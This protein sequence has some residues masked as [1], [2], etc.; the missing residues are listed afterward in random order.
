MLGI[1]LPIFAFSHCRDVVVEVSKSG[2]LGVLGAAYFT[3]EAFR[4]ELN[5]IVDHVG[6]KPFGVDIL[7]PT[8]Y[9]TMSETR[10]SP[11]DLPSVQTEYL[12]AYLDRNGIAPLPADAADDMIADEIRKIALT[13]QQALELVE[14]ALEYPISLVVNALGVPPRELV[15]RLHERGIKVGSLVGKPEHAIKQK[16]AGVDLVVA[17]GMEA[18]GHTGDLT[19]MILWPEVVDLIAPTPVLAA[20]GIGRGRQMAAALALG[21]EGIWCGSIWL[22]SSES[23]LT[24]DMKQRLFEAK[25]SEAIQSKARSGKQCRILK[26]RLTELWLED[27]APP[28]LPMPLQT[29]VMAE[30]RLRVERARVHDWLTCPV[31]QVVG[32][33]KETQSCRQIIFDL[34]SEFVETMERLN[35]LLDSAGSGSGNQ[36]HA[37]A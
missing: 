21:A 22:G 2:G 14:I 9:E 28:T 12:R 15:D 25:A 31:G 16:A 29:A 30:S 17:Q 7:L 8:T 26:S 10:I 18:G 24:P 5:W 11:T 33:M 32:Q 36:D 20:G 19:S 6:G 13:P 37:L 1:E 3:P 23:E 35:A 34:L 4:E 27:G